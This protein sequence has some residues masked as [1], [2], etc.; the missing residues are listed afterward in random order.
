MEKLA[1]VIA[2]FEK[3]S[4][5]SGEGRIPVVDR[6]VSLLPDRH[7][8]R[9]F[10]IEDILESALKDDRDSMEH[11]MFTVCRRSPTGLSAIRSTTATASRL[12]PAP[13]ALTQSGIRTF[14]STSSA[15]SLK[16]LTRAARTPK[17]ARCA[18]ASTTIWFL[19]TGLSV[20]STT[21]GWRRGWIG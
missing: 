8:T 14:S 15:R 7:P 11:P 19:P 9:D 16:A 1:D 21:K 12:R 3:A 10:F 5:R 20:G 17:A 6:R 13:M 4:V 18:S 2:R